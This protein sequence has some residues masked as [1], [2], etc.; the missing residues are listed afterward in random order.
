M[1]PSVN[2]VLRARLIG[3]LLIGITADQG[4]YA[5]LQ[6]VVDVRVWEIVLEGHDGG[7]LGILSRVVNH[8]LEGFALSRFAA[9]A[10]HMAGLIAGVVVI[11]RPRWLASRMRHWSGT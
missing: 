8:H 3:V 6:T 9:S 2:Q 11:L 1:R 4:T 5:A 7:P 10:V